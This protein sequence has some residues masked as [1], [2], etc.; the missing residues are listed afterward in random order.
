MGG[1]SDKSLNYLKIDSSIIL[2]PLRQ[3]LAQP[4]LGFPQPKQ[5]SPELSLDVL[6]D[7]SNHRVQSVRF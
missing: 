2:T 6:G 3:N 7:T 5:E 1:R 4:R